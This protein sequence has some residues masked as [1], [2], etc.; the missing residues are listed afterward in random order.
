MRAPPGITTAE[1]R[2]K[3]LSLERLINLY[4]EKA[5]ENAKSPVVLHGT[6]GLTTFVTLAESPVQAEV[7]WDGLYYVLSGGHLY[8]IDADGNDTD[9]GD[10]LITG[11]AHIHV[12]KDQL[13]ICDG[14]FG[15]LDGFFVYGGSITRGW[16]YDVD[17]GL[18]QI[19]D[20][21]FA[22]FGTSSFFISAIGDASDISGL[23]FASAETLPDEIT[24]LIVDHRDVWIFGPDSIE[25]WRNTGA[26]DF[27][28]ARVAGASVERFGT[29]SPQS[30]QSLDNRIAYLDSFGIVRL[31][32]KGQSPERI[33][34][35]AIET[36]LGESG[37]LDKAWS[38]VYIQEGH[39][40]Y[41]LTVPDLA[42]FVFDANTGLWHERQSYLGADWR[43]T[44]HTRAY[45]KHLVGD[46]SGKIL[47]MSKDTFDED[48]EELIATM[49][50]PPIQ[51][52]GA[53]FTVHEYQL[54]CEVGVGL[55]TGQ[56]KTPQ[57]ML[58]ISDNGQDWKAVESWRDLG[59]AGANN[60]RVI[61]RRLG[62]HRTFH[63]RVSISDPVKRALYA[64]YPG[65]E[66]DGR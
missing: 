47:E 60:T 34:T 27:P 52:D 33:S 53:R 46:T 15:F 20:T 41:V 32:G 22:S 49:V 5:P 31:A 58:E 13:V 42:T 26:S 48:G 8:S 24:T 7:F 66:V 28:L 59:I 44:T 54:D 4:A 37:K 64:L 43:A 29:K 10:T 21:A 18:N 17:N 35:H 65:I 25:I 3:P 55:A 61:W 11:E 1:G 36:R 40:F 63:T 57:V 12:S 56:G 51:A 9:L 38:F 16:V 45:G 30:V 50:P 6:P 39:E 2:S 62:Q 14:G 23:D 19:T